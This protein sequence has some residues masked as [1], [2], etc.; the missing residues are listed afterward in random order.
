MLE[1]IQVDLLLFFLV[2][3]LLH[4]TQLQSVVD[5]LQQVAYNFSSE[6]RNLSCK[7]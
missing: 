1:F 4:S 3:N 6:K 5:Y 7:Q 2:N